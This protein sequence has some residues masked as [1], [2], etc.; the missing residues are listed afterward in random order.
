[1]R[2]FSE[3]ILTPLTRSLRYAISKLVTKYAIYQLAEQ[4][5]TSTSTAVVLNICCPGL[6]KSR[7]IRHRQPDVLEYLTKY[8]EQFGREVEPA[9]RAYLQAINA[10][11]ES[12]G[13]F[14]RDC[15]IK[16]YVSLILIILGITN[17]LSSRD[18]VPSWLTDDE[19]KKLGR[20]LWAEIVVEL[21]K[22]APGA[23][24]NV[25]SNN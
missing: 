19:G 14:L 13:K 23:V 9:S 22:V 7:F 6:V 8:Y 12:H 11:R 3:F 5:G 25:L 20:Q 10:G 18:E 1:M 4:L 2:K 21:E 17:T 16:Q 15:E 24:A